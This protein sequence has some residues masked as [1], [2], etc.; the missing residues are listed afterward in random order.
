[1]RTTTRLALAACLLASPT[2]AQGEF[3][4]TIDQAQSNWSFGGTTSLGDI[5]GNPST[6]FQIAGT[7]EASLFGGGSPIGSGQMISSTVTIPGG[8]HAKISGLFGITIA[9]FDIDNLV[10]S[11]STDPFTV[12]PDGLVSANALVTIVSGVVTIDAPIIG[13]QT[14]D[15]TGLPP[16]PTTITGFL[17][18]SGSA[19]T[20]DSGQIDVSVDF[21]DPSSGVSATLT[22]SGALVGSYTCPSSLSTDVSSISLLSGGTQTMSLNTCVQQTTALYFL[23][24][25]ASGTTPGIP[26]DGQLLPLVPDNYTTFT[27]SNPSSPPLGNTLSLLD[28]SGLATATFTLPL[29]LSP[30]LAGLT[31]NHAYLVFNSAGSAVL[32]SNAAPLTLAP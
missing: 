18:H 21:D 20:L 17:S 11:I 31:L 30:S 29:G 8:I 28:G 27:L 22:I 5:E 2:L 12:P 3:L 13:Q 7:A 32:A 24:G 4:F 23:V 10:M 19:I 16:S 25:S 9:T 6:T 1:M 15:L 26:I 14:V